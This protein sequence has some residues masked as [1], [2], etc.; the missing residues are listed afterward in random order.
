MDFIWFVLDNLIHVVI[1]LVMIL[2]WEFCK[3][4]FRNWRDLQ[5]KKEPKY[6]YNPFLH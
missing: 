4:C 6:F 2:V 1:A 3:M 5:P